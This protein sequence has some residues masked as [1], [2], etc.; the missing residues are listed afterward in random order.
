ME[1]LR[2]GAIQGG[3]SFDRIHLVAGEAPATAAA[4]HAAQQGDLVVITPT[5]V[6]GTWEQI[7]SFE[8]VKSATSGRSGHLVAAE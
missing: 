2:E 4:L 3:A 1:L 6:E 5:D 8:K 7:T